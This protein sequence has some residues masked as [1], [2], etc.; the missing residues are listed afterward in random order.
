MRAVLALSGCLPRVQGGREGQWGLR[1]LGFMLWLSKIRINSLGEF[2]L[3]VTQ[4]LRH[5]AFCVFIM[6]AYDVDNGDDRGD[7]MCVS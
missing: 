1:G 4:A 6:L 5:Q 3:G 2:G 7:V